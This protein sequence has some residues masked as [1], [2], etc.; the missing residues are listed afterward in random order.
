MANGVEGEVRVRVVE[1]RAELRARRAA[2][3]G[4]AGGV[5]GGVSAARGC[6]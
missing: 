2:V 5:V 1:R 4:N 3:L 6:G